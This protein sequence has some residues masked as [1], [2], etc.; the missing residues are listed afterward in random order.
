MKLAIA[1]LTS[2]GILLFVFAMASFAKA[3]KQTGQQAALNLI[4][5]GL[6]FLFIAI[7]AIIARISLWKKS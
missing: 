7:F 1:I 3:S 6:C 2:S 4:G 5:P